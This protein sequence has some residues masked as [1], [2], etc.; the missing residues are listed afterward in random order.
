MYE[1]G[2]MKRIVPNS[3]IIL[4]P[5]PTERYKS[6]GVQLFFTPTL[7]P[8]CSSFFYS[9]IILLHLNKLIL[10]LIS[11]YT[12]WQPSSYIIFQPLNTLPTHSYTTLPPWQRNFY[13]NLLFL[14]KLLLTFISIYY[15]TPQT[16]TQF[17][18]F[19]HP[20][21]K[22]PHHA[23]TILPLA[24]PILTPIHRLWAN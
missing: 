17:L 8:H 7:L 16:A 21:N 14:N 1:L 11:F 13:M 15:P 19:L 20:L 18:L 24:S 22:L 5:W 9:Y 10:T 12:S 4:P 2:V 23:Y 3:Y 6:G